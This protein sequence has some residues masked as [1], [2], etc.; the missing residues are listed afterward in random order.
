MNNNYNNFHEFI[1]K[2]VNEIDGTE[3]EKAD[4]YEE[5]LSHLQL[6]SQQHKEKGYDDI[7]AEQLAMADFG[8]SKTIGNEMQEAMFPLRKF[9]LLILSFASIFYSFSVYLVHLVHEGDAHMVWLILSIGTSS[10]LLLFAFQAVP[11]MNRKSW[12][13]AA[14]LFHSFIFL[15]G[16]LL[17]TAISHNISTFL[18]IAALIILIFSIFL[19]YRTAIVDFHYHSSKFAKQAKRLHFLNISAGIMVVSFTLFFLWEGLLFSGGFSPFLL[20]ILIPLF[21]WIASYIVQMQ[22]AKHNKRKSAYIVA[23]IPVL[24]LIII[25]VSAAWNA[26]IKGVFM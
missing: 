11:S 24:L 3:E 9:L 17:V 21:L 20:T 25:V 8:D 22:L 13:N 4:I 1:T 14:L 6:A 18:T 2:I 7:T 12:I 23:F 26:I 19:I 5:L 16:A 15:V 10:V